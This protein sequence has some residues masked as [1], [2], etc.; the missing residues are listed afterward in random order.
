MCY[1]Y[2]NSVVPRWAPACRGFFYQA[3][4]SLQ[5]KEMATHE[6]KSQ[7]THK[8]RRQKAARFFSQNGQLVRKKTPGAQAPKGAQKA[9]Y[10]M[11]RG[12]ALW[13][14]K[15]YQR[16]FR[17]L[18]PCSCRFWPSCSDYSAQAIGKYG[19]AR[20]AWKALKRIAACHPFSRKSGY[21]PLS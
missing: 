1:T 8:D 5:N 2:F 7:D 13:A 12:L 15:V 16:Y 11:S 6:K 4:M 20:G 9:L 18:L 10:L 21:D 3:R 19:S 17:V 14:I